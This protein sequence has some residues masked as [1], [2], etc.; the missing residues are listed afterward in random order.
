M[1]YKKIQKQVN[2]KLD[3]QEDLVDFFVGIANHNSFIIMLFGIL[4]L[5]NVK[6]YAISVNKLNIYFH[7]MNMFGK[8]VYT[9]NFNYSEIKNL[10]VI[11]GFFSEKIIFSFNNG[12]IIKL[13]SLGL[14]S[15][16]KLKI[17]DNAKIYIKK[18]IYSNL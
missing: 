3:N 14:F 5:F 10:S 6:Y 2:E 13:K 9:D 1:N 4:A 11:K 8:I 18:Q 15:N 7:Q 17:S 12:R 16:K